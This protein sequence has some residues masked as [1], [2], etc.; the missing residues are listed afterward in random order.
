MSLPPEEELAERS[1]T[2]PQVPTQ[3]DWKLTFGANKTLE[4]AEDMKVVEA[5]SH[6]SG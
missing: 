3:D 6:N 4:I 1:S 2:A 5:Y